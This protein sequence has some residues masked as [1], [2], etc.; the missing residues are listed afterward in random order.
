MKTTSLTLIALLGAILP[1]CDKQRASDA[2]TTTET[3]SIAAAR[4]D[5][6]LL[7]SEIAGGLE[8]QFN[9]ISLPIGDVEIMSG[10]SS[11]MEKS[12]FERKRFK[13][14]YL[15]FLQSMQ[16][17]GLATVAERSQSDLAGISR[18]GARTFTVLPTE[19]SKQHRDE[20]LSSDDSLVVGFASCE[21]LNIVRSS[22]YQSPGLPK[23]E[24][25]RLILGT[26]RH[27]FMS[28]F[29]AIN[30]QQDKTAEFKFRAVLKFNPFTKRYSYQFADWGLPKE[31]GWQT[32]NVQ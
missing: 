12:S 6:E 21:V 27:S 17:I 1:A 32:N 28:W 31:D 23:S 5:E 7:R 10:L 19:L 14:D 16:K 30:P 29:L 13:E 4:A 25:Y 3:A 26:Y 15:D 11:Q 2:A 8:G 18:M 22:P 9:T 24:E 20:A